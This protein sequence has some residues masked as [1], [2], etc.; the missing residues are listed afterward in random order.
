MSNKWKIAAWT[1]F[2]LA[3]IV[4]LV[5]T[6]RAQNATG[7]EKPL[8]SISVVDENAFITEDELLTRVR[9]AGLYEVGQASESLNTNAIEQFVRKMPEVEEVDVFKQMGSHW[10]IRVKVRQPLARIFN[11][12]GQSFYVDSKGETMQPTA[13]F[14]ARVVVFSGFIPDRCDSLTVDEIINNASLK[15]IRK[16]DDIYRISDYVCHDP[17][18][19]AQISQVHLTRS[20][21]FVLVPQ[22]GT[23]KIIFGTANNDREVKEK[24][25]KLKVFY[26]EGL[27]YEGWNK[28][29]KIDLR[30]RNQ[31]VCKKIE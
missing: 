7:I 30:F 26:Q 1:A 29:E 8:V 11:R 18:L 14:Q 12:Y 17:F 24:M 13:N 31:I 25:E 20:G 6:V 16:L 28:Y 22:V 27:P 5:M 10:S 23:H 21:S 9:R 2:I 15:S 3:T 19:R 4:L